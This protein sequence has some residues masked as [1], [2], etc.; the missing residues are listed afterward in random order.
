LATA[1]KAC[2]LNLMPPK[3]KQQPA[4]EASNNVAHFNH[5]Y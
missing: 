3:R 4:G 1:L 2:V 5:R